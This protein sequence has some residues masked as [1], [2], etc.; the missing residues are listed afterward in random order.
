MFNFAVDP[1]VPNCDRARP[2][3]YVQPSKRAD[4]AGSESSIGS[5]SE[6]DA[7]GSPDLGKV[8]GYVAITLAHQGGDVSGIGRLDDRPRHLGQWRKRRE[9]GH[10][11]GCSGGAGDG[12][13]DEVK[14]TTTRRTYRPGDLAVPLVNLGKEMR[15][16]RANERLVSP[17]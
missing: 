10:V 9:G 14:V 11:S 15:H 7:S 1:G 5:K 3:I 6:R 16:G 13:N 4:F 17:P 8:R 12:P 2:K